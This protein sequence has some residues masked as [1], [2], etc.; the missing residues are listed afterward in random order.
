MHSSGCTEYTANGTCAQRDESCAIAMLLPAG[1]EPVN[2]D[3]V[4]FFTDSLKLATSTQTLTKASILNV[5]SNFLR[6]TQRKGS[7]DVLATGSQS[8]A[9]DRNVLLKFEDNSTVSTDGINCG[10]KHTCIYITTTQPMETARLILSKLP[11]PNSLISILMSTSS[12][13]L[14]LPS[15][16]FPSG[17]PTKTPYILLLSPMRTTC[18]SHL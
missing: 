11:H 1:T 15:D 18:P 5:P 14:G 8:I 3:L 17:F 6:N 12:L 16:L 9:F 10:V 4:C 7:L 13:C 2:A